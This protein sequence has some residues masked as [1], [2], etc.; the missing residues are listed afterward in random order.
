MSNYTMYA[1]GEARVVIDLVEFERAMDVI[2]KVNSV[3]LEKAIFV[4]DGVV[5]RASPKEIEEW[6][7]TGLSNR[8]FVSMVLLAPAE[9][10]YA[11]FQR[12]SELGG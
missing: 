10:R 9:E 7:F 11:F 5:L 12:L 8:D 3:P 6:K 4:R 2:A 1:D